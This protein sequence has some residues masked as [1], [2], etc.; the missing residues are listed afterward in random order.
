MSKK[1]FS[2][3]IGNL[4][5]YT[6]GKLVG[7]W[8]GMPC[9]KEDIEN[10]YEKIGVKKGN[11]EIFI[12]DYDFPSDVSYLGKCCSEYEKPEE[13]N[14]VA[15]LIDRYEPDKNAMQACIENEQTVSL[16]E[17]GNM[18][19]Q[20]ENI[21]YYAYDFQGIENI[22]LASKEE[23]YGYTVA[24]A[25]GL[26]EKLADLNI[27]SYVDFEAMGR[28]YEINDNVTLYEDGYFRMDEKD[29]DLNL[30][31]KEELLEMTDPSFSEPQQTVQKEY[32][33]KL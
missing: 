5:A 11:D 23:K 26:Y 9:S 32:V 12:A 21:P 25:T 8:L 33:P 20:A 6:E 7:E 10:L 30:Y 31:D 4:G 15:G 29:I 14:M 18:I 19:V 13:L 3:W 17:V 22:P 1:I 27:E 28:D 16:N 2:A 24:E